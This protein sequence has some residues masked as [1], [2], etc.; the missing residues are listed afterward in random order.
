MKCNYSRPITKQDMNRAKKFLAGFSI[1]TRFNQSS[2]WASRH[3]VVAIFTGTK[4]DPAS[5]SEFWSCVF[6]ELTHIL[7]GREGKYE[8]Y[9]LKYHLES[10]KI[11]NILRRT[12]LRAE[13]YVDKRA[14][15]TMKM[16]FPDMKYHQSY[17]T[18]SEIDW[19]MK[20]LFDDQG[21]SK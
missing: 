2:G 20:H 4:E 19:L 18:Q 8:V 14:E 9:H 21:T 16:M 15:K 10:K 6:H 17:R 12:A 3:Q 7:C 5:V 13:L 11:R 1:K